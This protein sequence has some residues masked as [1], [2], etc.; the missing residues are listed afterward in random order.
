MERLTILFC[1]NNKPTSVLIKLFT[2][3]NWSH[4]AILDGDFV[5]DSTLSTGVRRVPFRKWKKNYKSYEAVEVPCVDR[6]KAIEFARRQ[7]G[8]KY[9]PLGILSLVLKRRGEHPEKWFCS[10]LVAT[11]M[12]VQHRA[13]R[14]SPQFLWNLYKITEAW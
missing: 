5:I 2:L 1:E 6:K 4:C 12:G 7:V 9:D 8:K 14:L 10:E 13:W 11:A 3:S